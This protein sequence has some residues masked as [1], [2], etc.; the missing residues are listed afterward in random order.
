MI[1]KEVRL[2][3]LVDQLKNIEFVEKKK[4]DTFAIYYKKVILF[5]GIPEEKLSDYL[6]SEITGCCSRMA[7]TIEQYLEER[8]KRTE[9]LV[10]E[11]FQDKKE[12]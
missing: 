12:Q 1:T 11:L 9:Q 7:G 4:N 2:Q 6:M 3:R 8:K 5:E 10:L